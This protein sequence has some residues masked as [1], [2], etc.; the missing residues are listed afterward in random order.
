ML[1]AVDIGNTN[2]TLGA[3]NSNILEFTARLATDT[4]KTDD[5]YA[6]EIKQLLS[7][8]GI[9]PG[10][11]EDCI[12]SSVV[13]AVGKSISRA[14]S[15]LCQIVP[16]TLGP[17]VKTGLNIKIDNPAQLGADLVAGAVG[18]IDAYKMPCVI[19]D[20]GT[21]STVS[22]LDRNGAF[23][24]GVIAAGVRLT[25]KALTENTAQLPAIP[26]EA[27]KSV[28]GTNTTES[29]QSG[30]VYGTASMIDGLLEKITAELGETPTVLATGGLSKEV[31]SH[32]KTN[33]IYNENLLLEGLRVIY[34][35]NR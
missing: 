22:V 30:L 32:C 24:G 11:I 34:E 13:P 7:L 35:K 20:M 19:I 29:M 17:G 10:D 6:V 28:I 8:Y 5:Q 14:V 21:A 15:K 12:I 3:Y 23:L 9:E 33:I 27:P 31:I 16:L 1:L 25:L 18:A 4:R 2:I 26:I